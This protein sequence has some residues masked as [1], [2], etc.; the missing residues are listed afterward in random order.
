MRPP[1]S[2]TSTEDAACPTSAE[3]LE[4]ALKDWYLSVMADCLASTSSPILISDAK[5]VEPNWCW[6]LSGEV[7]FASLLEQLMQNIP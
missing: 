3:G 4:D 6:Y 5:E 1:T 2:D 7:Y